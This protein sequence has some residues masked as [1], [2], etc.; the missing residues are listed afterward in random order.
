MIDWTKIETKPSPINTMT[1]AEFK[2][3][4][5]NHQEQLANWLEVIAYLKIAQH[6]KVWHEQLGDLMKRFKL[7]GKKQISMTS[8]EVKNDLIELLKIM[9]SVSL[10]ENES[11]SILLY[12]LRVKYDIRT[13]EHEKEKLT[14]KNK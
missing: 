4:F 2:E 5:D 13:H 9:P 3:H 10:A 6:T 8:N 7:I 12:E 1:D 11:L 14:N